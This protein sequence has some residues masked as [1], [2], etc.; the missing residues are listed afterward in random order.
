MQ[1][2]QP[3]IVA[4]NGVI[5]VI[6]M[7]R[8]LVNGS[9]YEEFLHTCNTQPTITPNEE[10]PE[11]PSWTSILVALTATAVFLAVYRQRLAKKPSQLSY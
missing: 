6:W 1:S 5:N 10:I 11:F 4:E 9:M 2:F 3:Q 7:E 8:S